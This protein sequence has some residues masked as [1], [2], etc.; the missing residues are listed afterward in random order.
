LNCL[1]GGTYCAL[2]IATSIY[3]TLEFDAIG[4]A[5]AGFWNTPDMIFGALMVLLVLEYSRK[6]FFP[7]FVINI[8]LIVYCVYGWAVPGMFH[9]PGFDWERV[10][11]AMSLEMATGVYSRLPQL[12]LTLIGA[13]IL[14]LS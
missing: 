10:L 9:H 6:R 11:T 4:F 2:A 13:F 5:R 7:L 12:A 14:V 8:V 1:I 3:M